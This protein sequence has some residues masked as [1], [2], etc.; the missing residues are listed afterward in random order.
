M[1][2]EEQPRPVN[3]RYA[4]YEEFCMRFYEFENARGTKAR[5]HEGDN[6]ATFGKRLAEGYD[7]TRGA[8]SSE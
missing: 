8:G 4:T 7:R 3:R 1:V 5:Q 2:N 6:P